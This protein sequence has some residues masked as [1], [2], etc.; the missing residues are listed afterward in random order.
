M[1]SAAVPLKET[2]MAGS[3]S[4][5]RLAAGGETALAGRQLPH[6]HIVKHMIYDIPGFR[7][8]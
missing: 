1:R 8:R 6:P 7:L 3:G 2:R 4:N 5:G